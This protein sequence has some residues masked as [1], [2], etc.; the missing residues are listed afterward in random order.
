MRCCLKLNQYL[1]G[2]KR[3]MTVYEREES[4]QRLLDKTEIHESLYRYARGVD[5]GDWELVRSSYHPDAY[6]EHGSYKGGVDGLIT[7]LKERFSD[8]DN[9]THLLGNCIIEFVSDEKAIVETYYVSRRLREP[10]VDEVQI[11]KP[12]DKMC[13]ESWGRYVDIFERRNGEWRVAHRMIVQEASSTS[14]A[15]GGSRDLSL[16]WGRR[17]KSD[18]L[19]ETQ[20]QLMVTGVK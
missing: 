12:G 7:W 15:I 18:L 4:L 10:Q 14:L 9:S 13:R 6:D 2:W 16:R 8:V 1:N 11:V 5:R 3:K 17:D 20:K 19:F